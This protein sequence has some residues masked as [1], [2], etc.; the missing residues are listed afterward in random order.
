MAAVA[1]EQLE[2]EEEE[3][4]ANLQ[5]TEVPL[6]LASSVLPLESEALLY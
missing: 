1:P 3:E 5:Q 6:A 2:Q 4:Q